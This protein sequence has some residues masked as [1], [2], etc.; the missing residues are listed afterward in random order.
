MS[1]DEPY[2]RKGGLNK[3]DANKCTNGTV[4]LKPKHPG[5]SG[6]SKVPV[7]KQLTRKQFVERNCEWYIGKLNFVLQQFLI[8]ASKVNDILENFPTEMPFDP[9]DADFYMLPF[10][11]FPNFIAEPLH[12]NANVVKTSLN[13]D[14]LLTA[15]LMSEISDSETVNENIETNEEKNGAEQ[16]QGTTPCQSNTKRVLTKQDR[17]FKD[18][19][20]VEDHCSQSLN[21]QSENLNEISAQEFRLPDKQQEKISL[22]KE[23]SNE[24]QPP[25]N[26]PESSTK[27]TDRQGCFMDG[28]TTKLDNCFEKW[29]RSIELPLRNYFIAQSYIEIGE[30]NF[31]QNPSVYCLHGLVNWELMIFLEMFCRAIDWVRSFRMALN[32]CAKYCAALWALEKRLNSAVDEVDGIRCQME[33]YYRNRTQ[34]LKQYCK[35]VHIVDLVCAVYQ[36]DA[37]QYHACCFRLRI[38]RN[39]YVLMHESLLCETKT[40]LR[41]NDIYVNE[42]FP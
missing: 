38:M 41:E 36:L 24:R 31:S 34:L 29:R 22:E 17:A 11:K 15:Q 13:S 39:H 3:N 14:D 42:P 10:E 4:S 25:A 1:S 2:S 32:G 37:D 18:S 35:C 16:E 21:E 5:F 27:S 12:S 6:V 26:L 8:R 23:R 33:E 28:R 7:A 19:K 40:F 9:D 30:H 20:P